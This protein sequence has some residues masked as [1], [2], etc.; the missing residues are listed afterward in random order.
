MLQAHR[1][2]IG[3]EELEEVRK[4]FETG[5]LGMGSQVIEFENMVKEYLGVRNVVAVNTGSTALHITLDA[6]GIGPGD[7]V[8]TPSLTFCAGIQGIISLGAIPVFCEVDPDTL[9]IDLDDMTGRI[10]SKTK[11]IMPVHY[12]GYPCD[13]DRLLGIAGEK[14]VV[15]IEDAAHAFGSTYKGRKIGSIGDAACFSFDPIKNFTCGEGG[16]VTLNDD[17]FAEAIRR[18]R[19]LGI[20]RDSWQRQKKAQSWY[21][22]VVTQGYRYHMSNINA[23][24][25][26]VQLKK[27]GRFIERRR[28]IVEEY[29]K[30]FKRIEGINIFKWEI[31]E[32]APFMYILRVDGDR[33]D[34]MMDFLASKG[35]ASGVHYIPNHLQ[36]FFSKYATGLPAT[37]KVWKEI[38]TLPLFYDMT[39]N[40]VELV[41][42]S[43]R[44]FFGC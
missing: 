31:R 43:V 18:K 2:S 17:K 28:W 34:E 26:I 1:P 40:D 37:E 15:V 16:A 24:I 12:C 32:M 10:T 6:Y 11:A 42:S 8:I 25:G 29:N 36:P 30:A 22:E 21:Y 7:E 3:N 38:V 14:K 44:E 39:D 23:A 20:T 5:W 27:L 19:S 13:M 4:V 41:I 9:N 35:V 33:R